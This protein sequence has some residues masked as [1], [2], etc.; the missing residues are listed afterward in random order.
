MRENISDPAAGEAEEKT[1]TPERRTEAVSVSI[2]KLVSE[3]EPLT[4]A[5]MSKLAPMPYGPTP[6][7]FA[8]QIFAMEAGG[9]GNDLANAL[10]V[11]EG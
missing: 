9:H 10:E 5:D 8:L 6:T 11:Q 4:A 1:A 3:L 7:P 2:G